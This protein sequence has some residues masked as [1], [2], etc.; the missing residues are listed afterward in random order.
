MHVKIE[1]DS[2][3]PSIHFSI[4]TVHIVGIYTYVSYY[5][6]AEEVATF[7]N[8][9]PNVIPSL[10][11]IDKVKVIEQPTYESGLSKS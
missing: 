11:R 7:I 10:D 1:L 9:V 6:T 3:R 5:C 4:Q 2:R 8:A